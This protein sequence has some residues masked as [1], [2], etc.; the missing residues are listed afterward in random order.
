L[1]PSADKWSSLSSLPAERG[2]PFFQFARNCSRI[3][4][5]RETHWFADRDCYLTAPRK[6]DARDLEFVQS[7]YVR[8]Y[9]LH[10]E[11]LREQSYPFHE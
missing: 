2:N 6:S 3:L 5:V 1:S 4:I 11:L 10:I 9:D 7:I 8:G